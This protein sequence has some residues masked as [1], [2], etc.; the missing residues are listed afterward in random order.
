MQATYDCIIA[1]GPDHGQR[2]QVS[3]R[4]PLYGHPVLVASDGQLCRAAARLH[5]QGARQ[6]YV[7]AHPAASGAEL[8]G[9]LAAQT[10]AGGHPRRTPRHPARAYR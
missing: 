1:G 9:V 4:D 5:P 2:V 10:A 7:L 3:A 8:L 6:R